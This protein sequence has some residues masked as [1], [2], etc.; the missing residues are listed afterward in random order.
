[1]TNAN[2]ASDELPPQTPLLGTDR[3]RR[4]SSGNGDSRSDL[5]SSI[6]K[7]EAKISAAVWGTLQTVIH[8]YAVCVLMYHL[9]IGTDEL[10]ENAMSV[11]IDTFKVT[12]GPSDTPAS[13][14]STAYSKTTQLPKVA[15]MTSSSVTSTTTGQMIV[16]DYEAVDEL[17]WY[18]W[19]CFVFDSISQELLV[20]RDKL[21]F[22][23]IISM[24]MFISPLFMV[25]GIIKSR[26]GYMTCFSAFQF[27]DVLICFIGTCY[28]LFVNGPGI[29]SE[30]MSNPHHPL[31]DQ[32][33]GLNR[34][35]VF[36]IAAVILVCIL[37]VK[38][39]FWVTVM[40][41]IRY[42]KTDKQDELQCTLNAP[43]P[44]YETVMANPSTSAASKT[45]VRTDGDLVEVV[46]TSGDGTTPVY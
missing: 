5:R 38:L 42:L 37:V 32:V 26:P 14:G 8:L 34:W 2:P 31:R 45:V 25:I 7:R 19:T 6:S 17:T 21:Y 41:C 4:S 33:C 27:G 18:Y 12:P 3:T 9:C 36:F 28:Q 30:I 20:K 44:D 1:M 10:G 43:P 16:W 22:A 40:A 11:E 13:R 24:I 29:K 15:T 23:F 39:Y 46:V 35:L